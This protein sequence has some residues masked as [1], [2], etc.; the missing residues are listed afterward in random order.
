MD[1]IVFESS[2]LLSIVLQ[3]EEKSDHV[4]MQESDW[5][6]YISSLLI[7]QQSKLAR[8][9]VVHASPVVITNRLAQTT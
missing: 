4:W 5:L 7:T 3:Q 9:S 2:V 8:P 1:L 6:L